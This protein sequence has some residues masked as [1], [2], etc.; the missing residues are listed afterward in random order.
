MP[1]LFLTVAATTAAALLVVAGLLH[2]LPHLGR[3]GRRVSDAMCRAPAL[4][5]LVAYFTVAPLAAGPA[6]AGWAGLGAAVVGQLVALLVWTFIH[7]FSHPAAR[8]GPRIH[9]LISGKVGRARNYAA[10][11]CTGVVVPL[12]SLVRLAE[13]AVYPPL[14]WLVRLPRYNHGD[15]VNVSRHKFS[16]LVGHDLVWCLYCD[17]MTGVWSLGTEMLR[18]VE[19]FWCPIR[20]ASDKKCANCR[21]DFPDIDNG[22]VPATGSMAQVTATLDRMY[23]D[24]TDNAWYGHPVRLTVRGRPADLSPQPQEAGA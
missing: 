8:H 22:W 14:T 18:N 21:T 15:W 10:V 12:F 9:T 6:V 7:E 17:W 1:I 19:S 16:G 3:P 5:L 11:Y 13:V 4:D 23:G 2:L 20:F 24:A